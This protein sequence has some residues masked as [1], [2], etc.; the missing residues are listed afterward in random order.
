MH[1]AI[2]QALHGQIETLLQQGSPLSQY[3]QSDAR[4]SLA[5]GNIHPMRRFLGIFRGEMGFDP[6]VVDV[7]ACRRMPVSPGNQ[8]GSA[9]PGQEFRVILD[10]IDQF[11]HLLRR[12]RDENGFFDKRHGEGEVSGVL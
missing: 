3:I 11:E 9:A 12:Q 2:Q 8:L 6:V 4:R 5:Q 10:T 7:D 1:Q